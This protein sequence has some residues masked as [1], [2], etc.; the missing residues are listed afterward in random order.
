VKRGESYATSAVRIVY[1]EKER[2]IEKFQVNKMSQALV[3]RS[4]RTAPQPD[5]LL[6][7][8]AQHGHIPEFFGPSHLIDN[9]TPVQR[10]TKPIAS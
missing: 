7:Q 2:R 1:A 8:A 10:A 3:S 5:F 6:A 9:G 4:Q